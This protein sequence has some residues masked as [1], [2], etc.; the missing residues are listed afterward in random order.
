VHEPGG[1]RRRRLLAAEF[2]GEVVLAQVQDLQARH[3]KKLWRKGS[4]E[5]VP[6]EVE[7]AQLVQ[8]S[9]RAWQGAGEAP[10]GEVQAGDPEL[11][12]VCSEPAATNPE[13]PAAVVGVVTRAWPP[14][15]RRVEVV[16]EARECDPVG[17]SAAPDATS[18]GVAR[19]LG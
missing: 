3:M 19:I 2:A 13:P 11:T 4:M 10:A 5:R 9:Q 14:V 8:A 1:T 17:R 12:A 6:G 7:N 18:R 15:D 16:R